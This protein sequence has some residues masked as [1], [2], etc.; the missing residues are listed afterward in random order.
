MMEDNMKKRSGVRRYSGAIQSVMKKI[1][2]LILVCFAIRMLSELG[3]GKAFDSLLIKLGGNGRLARSIISFELGTSPDEIK[4]TSALEA[5]SADTGLTVNLP[6]NSSPEDLPDQLPESSPENYPD[7]KP[8]D[9]KPDGSGDTPVFQ[10]SREENSSP[11]AAV[12]DSVV[13]PLPGPSQEQPEMTAAIEVLNRT[14]HEIDINALL[15]E[16]PAIELSAD[17][18]QV[19]IIHTHSSEAYSETSSSRTLDK[20][21][22]VIKVGKVLAE[23]LRNQGLNVIHD[24]GIYDYPSYSGSYSRSLEAVKKYLNEYPEIQIVFDVHR[25]SMTL[26]DGS[27]YRTQ[28]NLGEFSSAQVMLLVATGEAGL[29]H[30]NW[31]ENLKFGLRL[32]KSME[33]SYPGLA[34]PLCISGE[35]YNQHTV[36]GSILVEIGTDGNSIDEAVNAARLFAFTAAPVIKELTDSR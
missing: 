31:K 36:P 16:A 11:A 35:R 27:K 12:A 13:I 25:D 6:E 3:V 32:Q 10:T 34:R 23:E 2:L 8:M 30:P 26:N 18:P 1:A 20:D 28:Y 29:E 9:S 19:L 15:R 17:K 14:S 21:L 33:D 22:N 7:D 24:T 5:L 4:N